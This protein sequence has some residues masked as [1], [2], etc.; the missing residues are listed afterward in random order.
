MKAVRPAPGHQDTNDD[1]SPPRMVAVVADG[2][3][4]HAPEGTFLLE[5]LRKAGIVIPTLC[6][7]PAVEPAG[8]CRLCLVEIL[9]NGTPGELV[10]AC[11]F[12]ITDGLQVRTRSERVQAMRR[13]LLDLLLARC[14]DTPLIQQLARE[15]GLDQTSYPRNTEAT[16]C[17]LCGLCTRVCDRVGLSAISLVSHGTERKV[18]PPLK[19]PPPDCVGCLA[20][21]AICPTGTIQAEESNGTRTIWGK[22]FTMLSCKTCGRALI[23]TAQAE[24]WSGR[25]RLPIAYF[26]TCDTCK[27]ASTAATMAALGALGNGR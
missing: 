8:A 5:V 6:H 18:A 12:P 27:R 20:C 2:R 4:L 3:T 17:I 9:R 23:T 24:Y 22:T 14:P 25:S 16:D 26:E 1:G 7:H 21:A 19:Q 13:N 10:T 15:Y 11:L